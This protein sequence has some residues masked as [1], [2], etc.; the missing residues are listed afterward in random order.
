LADSGYYSAP[1]GTKPAQ[2]QEAS[3]TAL[4]LFSEIVG[5]SVSEV[6]GTESIQQFLDASQDCLGNHEDKVDDLYSD[7]GSLTDYEDETIEMFAEWFL[8]IIRQ[9]LPEIRPSDVLEILPQV[10]PEFAIKLAHEGKSP[11]HRKLMFI[12]HKPTTCR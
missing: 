12:A 7:A 2:G 3:S 10:L 5:G 6:Y 1:S 8:A 4:E 11:G 9:H